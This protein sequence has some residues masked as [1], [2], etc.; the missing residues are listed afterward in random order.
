MTA[1]HWLAAT[2]IARAYADRTLSPVE[3]LGALLS[4]IERLDP[5]LHAFIRLDAGT[6]AK[7]ASSVRY[8]TAASI[9]PAE[10]AS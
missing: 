3:L 6:T 5:K 8:S 10:T 2:G 7:I 4:R 1:P 9:L